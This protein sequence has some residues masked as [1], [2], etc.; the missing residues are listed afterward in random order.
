MGVLAALLAAG[1][2]PGDDGVDTDPPP[3]AAPQTHPGTM[4]PPVPAVPADSPG[5]MTEPLDTTARTD[6]GAVRPDTVLR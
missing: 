1:C 2:G 4:P 5:V 3:A 6:M